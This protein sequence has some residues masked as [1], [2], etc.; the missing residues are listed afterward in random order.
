MLTDAPLP[1]DDGAGGW[2]RFALEHGGDIKTPGLEV[3]WVEHGPG[4]VEAWAQQH[5]GSRPSCWWAWDAPRVI[6]LVLM[7]HPA[8]ITSMSAAPNLASG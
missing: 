7:H 4:I 3:L 5:P 1:T 6:L 8:V 2:E